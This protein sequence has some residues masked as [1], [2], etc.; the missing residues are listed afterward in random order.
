MSTAGI[1]VLVIV[2][3]F[4]GF[5]AGNVFQIVIRDGWHWG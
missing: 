5:S 3:F 2:I 4:I 1:I